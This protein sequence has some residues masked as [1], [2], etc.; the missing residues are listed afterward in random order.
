MCSHVVLLPLL[1]AGPAYA[2]QE[3]VV[4]DHPSQSGLPLKLAVAFDVYLSRTGAALQSQKPVLLPVQAATSP[5]HLVASPQVAGVQAASPAR[6]SA[7]GPGAALGMVPNA[8]PSPTLSL[9]ALLAAVEDGHPALRATRLQARAAEQ[10]VNAAER[11]RWPSVALVLES[12]G[13][14][15][16]ALPSRQLRLEQTLWDFGRINA[17]VAE[18]QGQVAVSQTQLAL[19]RHDLLLQAVQAWQQLLA[20]VSR[21]RVAQR[22]LALLQGYRAQMV[23]RVEARASAPIDL[24]LIEAR[25]LQAQADL[26]SARSLV[27]QATSRLEQLSGLQP[28]AP[29]LQALDAASA[30]AQALPRAQRLLALDLPPL[31][32][33]HPAV[34]KARQEF[35]ALTRRLDAKKAEQW[36]QIYFRLDQPLDRSAGAAASST[37]YYVGL[38]YAPAAGLSG[39]AE[40]Q[41]LATRLEGQAFA[42][43]TA[44]REVLQAMLA[45]REELF[46]ARSRLEGLQ[47]SVDS[48]RAVQGSYQRQYEAAR[49]SWLDLLNTVRD[50][51]NTEYALAEAQVA[52]LG[53]LYRLQLRLGAQA[54]EL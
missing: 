26:A 14:G 44:Q 31:A 43:D 33:A 48:A 8:M 22:A 54:H 25:V 4:A 27:Q 46:S 24:E 52:M 19:A 42:A 41:S 18:S 49:K 3:A 45:D 20:G 37:R 16:A 7:T 2:V 6:V 30:L 17:I 53:A 21:E 9:S 40:V 5:L 13:G 50:L 11:Q 10:D 12:A 15:A 28:L 34:L 39:Q 32:T 23:R 36:P 1:V 47:L 51:S 29:R 38:R 35:D